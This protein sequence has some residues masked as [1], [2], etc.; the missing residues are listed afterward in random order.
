MHLYDGLRSSLQSIFSHKMRS[1]LTLMGIVIGV[2]AV[3]TMF[4]SIY[5][6]KMLIQSNMEGMGWNRSVLITGSNIYFGIVMENSEKKAFIKTK[7]NVRALGLIDYEALKKQLDLKSIYGMIEERQNYLNNKK[8]EI[9]QLKATNNS[10][11]VNKTYTLKSGRFF[12][13]FE[14][15]TGE[16]VCILG[17]YFVQKYFKGIDPLGQFVTV[18]SMRYRAVGVP[19]TL[20]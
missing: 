14:T 1:L 16:K 13:S 4:S 5:G 2:M 20:R 17:Y 19:C 6:L 3:V 15:D 18:G 8:R 11:F 12:R 7:E 9:V 10:F